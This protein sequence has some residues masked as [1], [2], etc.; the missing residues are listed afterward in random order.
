MREDNVKE[1]RSNSIIT[2]L[3]SEFGERVRHDNY[4]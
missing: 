4:S 1:I 2:E 3:I